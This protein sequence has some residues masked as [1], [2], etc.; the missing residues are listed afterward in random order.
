VPNTLPAPRP[1]AAMSAKYKRIKQAD[2]ALPAPLRWLT[3][4]FSSIT[5]SVFLLGFVAL[6]GALGSVPL[7]YMAIGTAWVL[8]GA[9]AAGLMVM[10]CRRLRGLAAAAGVLAAAASAV[11][12][13]GLAAWGIDALPVFGPENHATVI[14]RL[15]ALE[16]NEPEFF[17][18]WPL[19]L[20]LLLFVANMV[21]ATIRR[22]EFSVP[23]LGV[24]MV[25]TGIVAMALGSVFYGMT[26]VEG[27]MFITRADL[28][29]AEPV[30]VFYDRNDPA[31]YVGFAGGSGTVARHQVPL[32]ALGH[33]A[34]L[35]CLRRV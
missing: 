25:H 16:M 18:W 7:Y 11:A 20:V 8:I 14:Y 2:L 35:L 6:Y 30:S 1:P 13:A 10:A 3:R 32:D 12:A 15:R 17:A 27:D 21:W 26:K 24:L 23:R 19:R 5:L 31:L 29:G 22:I 4:A 33:G 34:G 28:P 9:A